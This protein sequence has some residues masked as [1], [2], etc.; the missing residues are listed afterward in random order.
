MTIQMCISPTPRKLECIM[1]I[2]DGVVSAN[3]YST[4]DRRADLA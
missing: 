3:Q 4:P 1:Q 2:G